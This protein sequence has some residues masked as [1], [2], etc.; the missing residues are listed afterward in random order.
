MTRSRFGDPAAIAGGA[1]GIT[2]TLVS[3]RGNAGSEAD[4]GKRGPA[5]LSPG[6]V[7]GLAGLP[8]PCGKPPRQV[9]TVRGRRRSSERGLWPV[10]GGHCSTRATTPWLAPLLC[11]GER[12]AQIMA[13]GEPRVGEPTWSLRSEAGALGPG[14]LSGR[15]LAGDRQVVL[16]PRWRVRGPCRPRMKRGARWRRGRGAGRSAGRDALAGFVQRRR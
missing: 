8:G 4:A 16:R 12:S 6:V 10:S 14:Q 7:E 11:R 1:G 3:S 2:S 5:A 15:A 13:T 9:D